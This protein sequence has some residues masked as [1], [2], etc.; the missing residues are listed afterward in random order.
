MPCV[1]LRH[2]WCRYAPLGGLF[3]RRIILGHLGPRI[4][5]STGPSNTQM[6]PSRPTV[7]C[8]PVTAARGSFATFGG[9]VTGATALRRQSK[10]PAYAFPRRPPRTFR[11]LHKFHRVLLELT[12]LSEFRQKALAAAVTQVSGEMRKYTPR[13]SD[14]E[15]S[16][17]ARLALSQLN[18]VKRG[19]QAEL[20][21][22]R[23]DVAMLHNSNYLII[24]AV[25]RG[26]GQEH[27]V[28]TAEAGHPTPGSNL[29][30]EPGWVR[31]VAIAD[32]LR[33]HGK[34]AFLT[35]G[36]PVDAALC[37]AIVVDQP[38]R[39]L[40]WQRIA[41]DPRLMEHLKS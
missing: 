34:A 14:P 39:R 13:V 16:S 28:T 37:D 36:T 5:R 8:D 24:R 12:M 3:E 27:L 19:L 35:F 18:K 2:R 30:H 17:A 9:Q 33:A 23:A 38:L 32:G 7:L 6:E 1:G 22:V 25:L 21:A 26:M 31:E 15:D 20:D 10:R 4:A 40:K 29:L 11:S 41:W